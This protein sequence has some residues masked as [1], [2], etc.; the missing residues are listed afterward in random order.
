MPPRKRTNTPLFDPSLWRLWK[1]G[2]DNAKCLCQAKSHGGQFIERHV[3]TRRVIR[4]LKTVARAQNKIKNK[5]NGWTGFIFWSVMWR[6]SQ[7]RGRCRNRSSYWRF[8]AGGGHSVV[9]M[10]DQSQRGHPP[11]MFRS[12][13]LFD[14]VLC[15]LIHARPFSLAWRKT[16]PQ[17]SEYSVC[18]QVENHQRKKRLRIHD[19]Q[20]DAQ[21]L[22]MHCPWGYLY[23]RRSRSVHSASFCSLRHR[24]LT[25]NCWTTL[26][27]AKKQIWSLVLNFS[28]IMRSSLS[29]L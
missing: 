23:H 4:E 18:P 29:I 11:A 16:E 3:L 17:M 21:R 6:R 19:D 24:R 15:C 2:A 13:G 12:S 20:N 5:K 22:T 8:A 9:M 7:C 14:G 10:P 25:P 27:P 28:Y 1:G 26:G